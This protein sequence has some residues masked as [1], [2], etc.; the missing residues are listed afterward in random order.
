VFR[1]I[2]IAPNM[3]AES[4]TRNSDI[5]KVLRRM[6]SPLIVFRLINIAPNMGAE[7]YKRTKRQL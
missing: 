4:C 7:S 1:L 2:N 6:M 3:G 5:T